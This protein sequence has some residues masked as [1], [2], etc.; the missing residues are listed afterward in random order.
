MSRFD[1]VPTDPGIF[2]DLI[3]KEV[4]LKPTGKEEDST[5]SHMK[6][7]ADRLTND[8]PSC[9]NRDIII[10]QLEE[11]VRLNIALDNLSRQFAELH[12]EVNK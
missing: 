12:N 4:E 3:R 1:W 2:S 7:G 11:I 5:V 10:N 8:A 9:P 6:G